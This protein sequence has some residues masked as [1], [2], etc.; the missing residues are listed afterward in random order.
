[1]EGDSINPLTK[2]TSSVFM[3]SKSVIVY[4]DNLEIIFLLWKEQ[5]HNRRSMGLLV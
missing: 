4:K 5:G 2:S 1:M 3:E